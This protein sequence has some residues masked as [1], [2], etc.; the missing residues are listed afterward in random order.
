L[1]S[2]QLKPA[3]RE[4]LKELSPEAQQEVVD[5]LAEFEERQFHHPDV[6][7]IRDNGEWI[8]RL[9]IKE[10]H[11]DH[12]AFIDYQEQVFSVL[13]IIHRDNAYR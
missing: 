7:A 11:T 8:W 12:R 3:A 10:E 1:A 2:L 5:A 9:K 13:R 4:S 6:K